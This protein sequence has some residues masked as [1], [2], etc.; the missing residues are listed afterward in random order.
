MKKILAIAT[1]I[2]LLTGCSSNAVVSNESA[3][4]QPEK[5][6]TDSA[7]QQFDSDQKFL[8]D[9]LD[10]VLTELE[11]SSPRKKRL[12]RLG[13]EIVEA[14]SSLMEIKV[15]DQ[16]IE[17]EIVEFASDM[18]AFGQTFIDGYDFFRDDEPVEALEELQISTI[19]TLDACGLS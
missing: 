18:R 4:P 9:L 12:E 5:L 16:D 17:N 19:R 2:A 7:C 3:A 13:A 8:A 15:E 11:D 6:T 10:L 14:A 1:S